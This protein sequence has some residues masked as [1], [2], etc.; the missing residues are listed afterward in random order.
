[1][2]IIVVHNKTMSLYKLNKKKKQVC[3]GPMLI[4][5]PKQSLKQSE[6]LLALFLCSFYLNI[7]QWMVE[8]NDHCESHVDLLDQRYLKFVLHQDEK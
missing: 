5:Q 7:N 1:M 4:V 3:L 8:F 2:M 6:T